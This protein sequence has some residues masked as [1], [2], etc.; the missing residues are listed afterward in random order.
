MLSYYRSFPNAHTYRKNNHLL[1]P[2]EGK[3]EK[4]KARIRKRRKI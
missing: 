3:K 1:G 4:V 2:N